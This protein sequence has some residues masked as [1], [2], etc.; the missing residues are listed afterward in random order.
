MR[1]GRK[2]GGQRRRWKDTTREWT[3]QVPDDIADRGTWIKLVVKSSVV[4][5]TVT[6]TGAM[7][8]R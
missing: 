3:R 4:R 1:E 5:A 8:V 6:D 2:E 7:M